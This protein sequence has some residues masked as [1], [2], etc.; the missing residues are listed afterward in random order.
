M[1]FIYKTYIWFQKFSLYNIIFKENRVSGY[2]E[3]H[4]LMLNVANISELASAGKILYIKLDGFITRLFL[5][6][7]I[8]LKK[9]T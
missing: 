8:T 1:P 3:Q 5:D 2:K 4:T 6:K 7:S 9:L